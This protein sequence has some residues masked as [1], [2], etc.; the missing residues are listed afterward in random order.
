VGSAGEEQQVRGKA[1]GNR[2]GVG[3]PSRNG[4][5]W[6]REACKGNVKAWKTPRIAGNKQ[7]AGGMAQCE[8]R[9][10]PPVGGQGREG[11]AGAQPLVYRSRAQARNR[12]QQF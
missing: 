5:R 1:R 6:G 10:Q 2:A 4:A 11:M 12:P 7:N 3:V 8:D 9:T